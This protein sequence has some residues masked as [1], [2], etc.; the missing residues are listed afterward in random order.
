MMDFTSSGIQAIVDDEVTKR[1]VPEELK[2]WNLLTRTDKL[3]HYKSF[4]LA[5]IWLMGC[6]FR[7]LFL[8]P[9]RFFF[10]MFGLFLLIFSTTMI[11]LMPDS[12][13]K[14]ILYN[15]SIKMCFRVLSLAL[16]AMFTYHNRENKAK[17]GGIC[18][19]NHTTP[20]DAVVLQCDNAYAMVAQRHGGFLGFLQ[21]TLDK[22]SKHIYF[23]RF[24]LS[25][26]Q[27]KSVF[28]LTEDEL[29]K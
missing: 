17:P 13:L 27:G 28:Y 12:K 25:D 16:S 5:F 3:Y 1:F 10:K 26:R 21:K 6:M 19:A 20:I 7:Y 18:V 14:R 23:N 9:I 24:E 2:I 11:S 29:R 15:Y 8:F 22:A 4:R